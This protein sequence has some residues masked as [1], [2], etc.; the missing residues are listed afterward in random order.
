MK[1]GGMRGEVKWEED[2]RWLSESSG[3]SG[4]G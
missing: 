4:E 2:K 3:V 1:G